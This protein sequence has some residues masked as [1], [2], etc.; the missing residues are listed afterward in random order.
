[1]GCTLAEVVTSPLALPVPVPDVLGPTSMASS[2]RV[3]VRVV[4]VACAGLMDMKGVVSLGSFAVLGEGRSDNT[5]GPGNEEGTAGGD[6]R[7]PG[8]SACLFRDDSNIP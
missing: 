1:M 4:I 5:G 7:P 3:G 2:K 8:E 6:A